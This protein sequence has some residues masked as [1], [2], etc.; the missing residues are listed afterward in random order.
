MKTEKTNIDGVEIAYARLGKGVPLVLIH[1]YP[2][3]HSIWEPLGVLLERDFD[4]IM[5]DMRGFGASQ[6]VDSSGSIDAYGSDVA[7]LLREL[8]VPQ[9]IFAGHSMGGYVALAIARNQPAIVTGLGLISSQVR[10]DTPER[11]EGRHASARKVIEEG[12]GPVA[13][14]M[15]TQLTENPRIQADM[16][17]LIQRQDPAGLASA[18]LAMAGRPDSRAMLG[19]LEV[20][21]VAI[22][23]DR[24]GLIPVDRGREV[25]E[26]L[27][28]AEL[29]TVPGAGHLPMLENP[30][31]V[32]SGLRLFL[33]RPG[34]AD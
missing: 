27:P 28:A 7:G 4:L 24:D 1:G 33:K 11:R 5:P 10:A 8:Q 13:S 19:M 26:L 25:K 30:E 2:L 6:I 18:L 34:Q 32:A 16:H 22:H 15:S 17:D 20:P 12:V 3:D 14:A 31:A 29:L 21:V 23:G 9:A